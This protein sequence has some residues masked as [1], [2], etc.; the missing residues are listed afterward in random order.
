MSKGFHFELS[1]QELEEVVNQLE[2]GELTLDNALKQFE[3][4]IALA[5]RCQDVLRQAEQKIETLTTH[6]SSLQPKPDEQ[7]SD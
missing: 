4:G 6:H 3:K 7:S 1:L 5:R 2:K